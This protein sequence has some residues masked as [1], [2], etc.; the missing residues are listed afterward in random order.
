MRI[1]RQK[2][3]T[4]DRGQHSAIVFDR[5]SYKITS[6]EYTEEGFLRVPARVAR[7]G[8]QDYRAGELG[9]EGDPNRIVKVFRPPEEVF[10]K[11]SLD[12][13]KGADITIEHP[14]E[15][16]NANT[17]R[18]VSVGT[19]IDA[20][21]QDG[22]FVKCDLIIKD[23][24][25]IKA[26]EDGK[27]QLSVGYSAIYDD[28]VPDDVDYEFIQRD[29][30]VNH[31]ALVDAARA[32]PQARLFDNEPEKHTMIIT[33]KSG[34]KVEV[35]D[36]ANAQ[37]ILDSEAA[38]EK[39]VTDAE[40][41]ATKATTDKDEM[42]AKKDEAEDNLE[43][44][45]EKTSDEAINARVDGLI[46]IKDQASKV[47]GKDF[48][49]DSTDELTLKR[50]ALK[51]SQPKKNWDEQS[52]AYVLAAFDIA[53]EKESDDE[54]EEETKDSKKSNDSHKQLAAD[55]ASKNA[56]SEGSPRQNSIDSMSN[57][58]KK[59]VAGDK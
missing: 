24:E 19:T 13:Y 9:L 53:E 1:E 47:G 50:E 12:T 29:I 10:N 21:S 40:S 4:F 39:K 46:V 18:Q 28:N 33:L 6:R 17:Y 32:G 22:D 38:L 3:F 15:M 7:T 2:V 37:L 27:V 42:E 34:A 36:E 25:G 8:I 41:K 16:V 30:Q 57:A 31:I 44:E 5:G 58:W 23:K 14:S 59:T 55:M 48:V 56:Q 20:G 45:K 51:A 49:C 35:K 52:D 26:A 54:E 11:A 43:K